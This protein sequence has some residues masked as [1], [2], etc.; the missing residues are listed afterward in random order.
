MYSTRQ[1]VENYTV[2]NGFNNNNFITATGAVTTGSF[3]FTLA[4]LDQVSQLIALFDQYRIDM[5]EVFIRPSIGGYSAPAAGA[6][7]PPEFVVVADFDNLTVPT[8]LAYVR[9]YDNAR[10]VAP[11]EGLYLKFRPILTMAA[12]SGGAFSGYSTQGDVWL[13]AANTT[14]QHYGIKW[15]LGAW[16]GSGIISW[17]VETYYYVSFKSTI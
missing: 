13:D 1:L 12:Y 5:V 7:L 4:D 15:A 8:G 17:R 16:A 9:Q 6:D 2:E 14:V 10:D 11:Y 3:G